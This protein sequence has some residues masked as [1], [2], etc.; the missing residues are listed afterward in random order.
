[1]SEIHI[2]LDGVYK[3]LAALPDRTPQQR[4]A[5]RVARSAA[6]GVPRKTIIPF[7]AGGSHHSRFQRRCPKTGRFVA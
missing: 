1:M 2:D 4:R 5:Y 3:A 7:S 6:R